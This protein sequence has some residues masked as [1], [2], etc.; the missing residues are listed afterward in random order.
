MIILP[1]V[2]DKLFVHMVDNADSV[3]NTVAAVE[4]VADA[5]SPAMLPSTAG[6]A[7]TA[8]CIAGLLQYQQCMLTECLLWQSVVVGCKK[9]GNH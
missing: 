9:V 6:I 5:G 2:V 4:A 3:G 7:D 1:L 8:A